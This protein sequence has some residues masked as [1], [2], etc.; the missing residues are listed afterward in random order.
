METM[1][2]LLAC[3]GSFLTVVDPFP[4]VYATTNATALITG[5]PARIHLKHFT[6][7]RFISCWKPID[8]K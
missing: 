6:C 1:Q 2:V 8:H 4:P 3:L 5:E 7:I